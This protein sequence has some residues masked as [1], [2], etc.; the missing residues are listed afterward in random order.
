MEQWH[1]DADQLIF[2]AINTPPHEEQ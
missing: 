2:A 1:H